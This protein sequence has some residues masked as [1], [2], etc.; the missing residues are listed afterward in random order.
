MEKLS[1]WMAAAMVFIDLLG[2]YKMKP[3]QKVHRL[4][5][6]PSLLTET[7]KH[8]GSNSHLLQSGTLRTPPSYDSGTEIRPENVLSIPLKIRVRRYSLIC[9]TYRCYVFSVSTLSEC[10]HSVLAGTL[11]SLSETGTD[12]HRAL[13]PEMP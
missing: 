8:R 1:R 7:Y 9:N 3:E 6:K 13:Y 4:S 5:P 12:M 10:G 11:S 2:N